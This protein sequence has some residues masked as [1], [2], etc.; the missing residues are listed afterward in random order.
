MARKYTAAE[1]A[2]G[3]TKLGKANR[4]L[5]KIKRKTAIVQ[6]AAS[7]A[8]S[9][10]AFGIGQA[11]KAKTAWKEYEAGY[12][13]LG[14]EG[15]E[16]P[17]FG[18]KGYFKGPEG[19][20]QIGGSLYDRSKIQKAGAFLGSEASAILDQPARD[21]YLE[22]VAPGREI[23]SIELQQPSSMPSSTA[24]LA[25]TPT[26][27]PSWPSQDYNQQDT[28]FARSSIDE[29]GIGTAKTTST[30]KPT[31]GELTY[32]DR[33]YKDVS[34]QPVIAGAKEPIQESEDGGV[35]PN[36]RG[37]NLGSMWS[38]LGSNIEKRYQKHGFGMGLLK[39]THPG[40]SFIQAQDQN[41]PSAEQI[42]PY[43][44]NPE[45]NAWDTQIQNNQN[46]LYNK[47]GPAR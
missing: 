7:M 45:R 26:T 13:A 12:E 16:R 34:F 25:V 28:R 11:N 14:G 29:S 19:E 43:L 17:K 2:S 4:K 10:A 38:Q 35:D 6:G 22:R 33:P 9:V 21:Q 46:R 39:I 15:F 30:F 23:S 47:K 1:G 20:V 18:Q 3:W 8:G 44:D 40:A 5:T 42:Q 41:Q 32:E 24:G 36:P 37:P 27:S 31:Y